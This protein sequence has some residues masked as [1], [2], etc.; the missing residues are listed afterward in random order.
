MNFLL[1][2]IGGSLGAMLRYFIGRR[3]QQSSSSRFPMGTFI[4]NVTGSFLLGWLTTHLGLIDPLHS[5]SLSL[6]FGTG[7]C[8]AYTTFSTFSHETWS[9]FTRGSRRTALFYVAATAIIGTAAA[10]LGL[11]GWAV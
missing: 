5:P 11:Y 6:L 9:L 10:G 8:G 7:L 4:V 3:V 1:V 2:G